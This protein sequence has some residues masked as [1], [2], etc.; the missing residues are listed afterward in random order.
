MDRY[1][2]EVIY[3]NNDWTYPHVDG[4]EIAE[5]VERAVAQIINLSEEADKLRIT[6][7]NDETPARDVSEDLLYEAFLEWDA[8]HDLEHNVPDCLQDAYDR[9]NI[10]RMVAQW[11]MN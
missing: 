3:G 7:F 1:L 4:W 2:I 11:L 9:S 5:S 10:H 8:T 6:R